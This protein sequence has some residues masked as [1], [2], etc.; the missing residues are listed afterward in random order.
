[1]IRHRR[2][3]L[4]GFITL[5]VLLACRTIPQPAFQEVAPTTLPLPTQNVRPVVAPDLVSQQDALIGLYERVSQ[6]V[7]AIQVLTESGDSLGSGFVYDKDGHIITNYHVVEGVTDLEVDFPTGLKV[8]GQVI[9][10]DLDSDLAVIKIEA[11]ADVLVPLPL[12]NPEEI[13]VGQTVVAIGN[14]FGYKGS[15]SVGIVSALGRT[16]ES[17]HQAPGGLPFTAGDM[18]QTDTAI[19]PGNSGGP[20]LNLNGEVIGVNRAIQTDSFS[21]M[22]TPVNSGVGF[23]ISVGIVQRVVPHLIA[24]GSYDYPYLGVSSRDEISLL[25]QEALKL[26]RATGAYVVLVTPDSP[27]DEAGLIGDA[28]ENEFSELVGGGDLIIAIDGREVLT[29]GDLLSYLITHKSPG[30]TI[31]LTILRDNQ[32]MEVNLTLGKRP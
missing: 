19:N 5:L 31:V 23:A 7:V 22:G 2:F 9:G 26:P 25:L 24:D 15:M 18:I 8:R 1:M 14:P 10:T 29:F 17:M 27:A 20:L 4:V 3:L 6:G 11:P 30:D 21:A 13:R 16:L 12:G 28:R 32:Q